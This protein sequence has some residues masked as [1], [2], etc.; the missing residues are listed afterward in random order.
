[1]VMAAWMPWTVVSRSRLMSLIMTFM[2]EPAKLQMN[3]ASASGTSTCRNALDGR[4]V[5]LASATSHLLPRNQDATATAGYAEV[6]DRHPR[7]CL[8]TLWL[9]YRSIM[10]SV[11]QRGFTQWR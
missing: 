7:F 11:P 5:V 10:A 8:R 6:S 4:P 2:L 1:M 9:S 3:C